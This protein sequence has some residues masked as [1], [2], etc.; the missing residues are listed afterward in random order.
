MVTVQ[1][2]CPRKQ[3]IEG[4][5][6]WEWNPSLADCYVTRW[7]ASIHRLVQVLSL[8]FRNYSEKKKKKIT[9]TICNWRNAIFFFF[10]N[11]RRNKLEGEIIW[12]YFPRTRKRTQFG[13]RGMIRY[14][15]LTVRVFLKVTNNSYFSRLFSGL[16]FP[17]IWNTGFACI[18]KYSVE[19][20]SGKVK[21]I[22]D[23]ASCQLVHLPRLQ[24]S[25]TIFRLEIR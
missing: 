24:F 15:F 9:I 18:L 23:D 19:I 3:R 2:S 8:V 1:D 25:P 14:I 13:N 20:S 21:I 6:R 7:L 22:A 16:I 5:R 10:G 4:S 17:S 12:I 11:K